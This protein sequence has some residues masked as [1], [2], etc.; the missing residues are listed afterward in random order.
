[1]LKEKIRAVQ[2]S[3]GSVNYLDVLLGANSF[4]D[5]IDRFSAVNTLMEA[6][7]KI[8]KEQAEDKKELEEQMA[9]LEKKRQ[10]QEA[11]KEQL[12]SLKANS[13]GQKF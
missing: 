9:S 10:E 3:G 1:M 8:L 12:V 5:F 13:D 6:D 2:V 7:R 4:V 11:S